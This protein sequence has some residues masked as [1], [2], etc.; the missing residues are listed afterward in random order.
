M[1]LFW[2]QHFASPSDTFFTDL[3]FLT[4]MSLA[5]SSKFPFRT[6]NIW[7]LKKYYLTTLKGKYVNEWKQYT[8]YTSLNQSGRIHVNKVK[9]VRRYVL[10]MLRRYLKQP[11]WRAPPYP[12]T[13]KK[14]KKCK[15]YF[16]KNSLILK[17]SGQ[18]DITIE[19]SVFFY[20]G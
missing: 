19:L 11:I 15:K 17:V 10:Y 3:T 20:I 13:L 1:L 6:L 9:S 5:S 18:M 16:V 8:K 7:I 4:W 2:K 14:K 12:P